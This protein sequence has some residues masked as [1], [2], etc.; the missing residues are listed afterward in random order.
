MET[1]SDEGTIKTNIPEP[2]N[3][4][5]CGFLPGWGFSLEC[6]LGIPKAPHA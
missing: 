4:A 2:H 6:V 5:A 1:D 3:P